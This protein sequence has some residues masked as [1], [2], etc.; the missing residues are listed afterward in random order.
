MDGLNRLQTEWNMLARSWKPAPSCRILR[1]NETWVNICSFDVHVRFILTLAVASLCVCVRRPIVRELQSFLPNSHMFPVAKPSKSKHIHEYQIRF[2]RRFGAFI[3][4]VS[5]MTIYLM[6]C[7]AKLCSR[8]FYL[9]S[10]DLVRK[11]CER[12]TTSHF[13]CAMQI[14]L[15]V[16]HFCKTDFSPMNSKRTD[17]IY[18]H[19]KIEK[20]R[21]ISKRSNGK[22]KSLI[23][24]LLQWLEFG[25]DFN[26]A[27]AQHILLLNN[28]P[29]C[30]YRLTMMSFNASRFRSLTRVLYCAPTLPQHDHTLRD[31]K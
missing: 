18:M 29:I 17:E 21:I 1:T 23:E 22:S 16:Q 26:S 7:G 30:I 6:V 13:S 5:L 15:C 31:L 9:T 19:R 10:R 24:I 3:V 11:I 2:S 25:L 28:I 8:T 4:N 12:W 20:S 27:W 14:T